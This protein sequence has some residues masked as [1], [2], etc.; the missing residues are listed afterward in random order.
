MSR[1]KA[2]VSRL[3]RLMKLHKYSWVPAVAG[4]TG[5]R[6]LFLA[7]GT[8][9]WQWCIF[10]INVCEFIKK[11]CISSNALDL[12][13]GCQV[14][15][16]LQLKKCCME[17][18][19]HSVGSGEPAEL[20]PARRN[21]GLCA[22]VG[23][24]WCQPALTQILCWSKAG[25]VTQAGGILGKTFKK[26]QNAARGRSGGVGQKWEERA[27]EELLGTDHSP[28]SFCCWWWRSWERRSEVEPW[29]KGMGEKV[30]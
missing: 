1:Q 28:Y 14:N 20:A 17:C 25:W 13:N 22:R 3:T 2:S 21:Q 7:T 16:S 12:L 27:A 30:F 26:R 10:R 23:H 6:G 11:P 9:S 4:G 29:K 8:A 5:W 18:R 19:C 15:I 24:S